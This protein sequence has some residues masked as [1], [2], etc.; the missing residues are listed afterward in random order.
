MWS[1]SAQKIDGVGLEQNGYLE[2]I[3]FEI[4]YSNKAHIIIKIFTIVYFYVK[5][6]ES[7]ANQNKFSKFN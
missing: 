4:D 1:L 6:L 2:W 5:C 3:G 7:F